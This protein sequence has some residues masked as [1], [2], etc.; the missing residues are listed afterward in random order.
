M[1][2]VAAIALLPDID[3]PAADH[4]VAKHADPPV[5]EAI[6]FAKAI[7]FLEGNQFF[8]ERDTPVH[9][10]AFSVENQFA[11]KSTIGPQPKP[12]VGKIP[13]NQNQVRGRSRDKTGSLAILD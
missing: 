10:G 4:P 7:R 12:E 11:E 5:I 3:H 6:P 13:N 9:P 2:P 1:Q 8:C